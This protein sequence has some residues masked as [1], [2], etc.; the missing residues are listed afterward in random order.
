M[1]FSF[2]LIILVYSNNLWDIIISF[3]TFGSLVI[4][5]SFGDEIFLEIDSSIPKSKF[6]SFAI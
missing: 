2:C 3:T 4:N 6:L 5:L 1:G